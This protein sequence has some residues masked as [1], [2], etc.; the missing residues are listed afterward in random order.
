MN[1]KQLVLLAAIVASGIA[2]LDGS[3]VTLALPKI[4]TDMHVQ[5]A[6]MQWVMDGYLLSL[7]SLILIGGSL[8]DII[9]HKQIF[10]LGAFGFGLSSLLCGFAPGIY[11][12]IVARLLQGA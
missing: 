8:G 11:F 2:F 9:G 1:K 3:V 6:G 10:I 7:S 12:L 5:L 4:A